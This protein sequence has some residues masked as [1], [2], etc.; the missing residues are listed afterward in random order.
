MMGRGKKILILVYCLVASVPLSLCCGL[1]GEHGK[2]KILVESVLLRSETASAMQLLVALSGYNIDPS[3][4]RYD[5]N[6]YRVIYKTVYKEN[7]IFASGV[8]V[9]PSTSEPVGM[10]SFQH[11]TI[12]AH[13]DAPSSLRPSDKRLLLY[14]AFACAGLITVIPDYIGFGSSANIL[15]P[16][17]VE[18]VLASSIIDNLKAARELAR[19][20]DIR[21]NEKL[22]L[23]GYSEGG[24]ATMAAHKFI[25]ENR[26]NDFDLV[27]SFPA[28]GA[29]DLK[30]MQEY[31]FSQETYHNPYFLAYIALAYK[32]TFNWTA[33]LTDFFSK[34]YIAA[35]SLFDGNNSG[36]KINAALTDSI[37]ALLNKD[38]L[39]NID[40]DPR[41]QYIVDALR[42]NSL[43]RWT[44]SRR[45][46]MYHGDADVTIPFQN[47]VV[48][49]EQ[50]V[51]NGT[52]TNNLQFITLPGADHGSGVKPYIEDF[53]PRLLELY[54]DRIVS[55]K[56]RN[57]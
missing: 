34:R 15:H 19:S 10:L 42:Q 28:A 8:V 52:S 44:P 7:P 14:G 13:G 37:S 24:Y 46:Y 32:K 20:K 39:A 6:I 29:Y 55:G 3:A 56:R 48:T 18:E 51:A 49:Y 54:L 5:V 2:N 30:A 23:A 12:T 53:F 11:G 16:Y 21:F 36:S 26:L 22:F 9:L 31:L 4:M 33:P 35:T 43:T 47:S 40:S 38:L 41:Y 45:M 27:A 57:K 50:L 1:D 25:E 17:Y